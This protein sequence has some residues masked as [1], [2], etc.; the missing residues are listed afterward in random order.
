[1]GATWD[2]CCLYHCTPRGRRCVRDHH[3]FSVPEAWIHHPLFVSIVSGRFNEPRDLCLRCLAVGGW[4]CPDRGR[5]ASLCRGRQGRHG[6]FHIVANLS[7]PTLIWTRKGNARSRSWAG[8]LATE[9]RRLANL[10][11]RPITNGGTG[12]I[13]KGHTHGHTEPSQES[14]RRPLARR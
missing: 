5:G 4:F 10:R 3:A 8:D 13:A 14:T 2:R 6:L 7:C 9:A 11:T 1:M 12:S